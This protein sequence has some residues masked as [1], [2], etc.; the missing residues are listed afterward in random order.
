M[1]KIAWMMFIV[2]LA[3]TGCRH[4][5]DDKP[6]PIPTMKLVMWDMMKADEWYLSIISKDS[7]G[8]KRK[9]NIRLYEQVFSIHG[10]T[11][12]HF[13][14]SYKYYEAH[15]VQMKILIDSIDQFSVRERNLLFENNDHGQAKA[16]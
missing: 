8:K 11:R 2:C 13:Y 7:T 10:I 5:A 12:T 1:R 4:N 16:R 15:P 3:T 9:D 6:L 14:N